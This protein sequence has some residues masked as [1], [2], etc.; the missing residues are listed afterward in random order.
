MWNEVVK[1]MEEFSKDSKPLLREEVVVPGGIT[2]KDDIYDELFKETNDDELDSLTENCLRI[3]CCS[4][5]ILLR[6][7]LEDQLPG[8]K[9]F[10]PSP[11]VMNET[12]NTPKHNIICECDFSQLDRQ[13][14]ERPQTGSIALSGMVCFINNKTPEYMESLS[15]EEKHKMIERTLL[16]KKDYIKK[17]QEMK[18]KVR[19]RKI[20]IMEERKMKIAKQAEKKEQRK[21]S[22]DSKLGEYSGFWRSP[23]EMREKLETIPN[24]KQKDAL[25]TQIKYRKFVLG[26]KIMDKGL[27]QLQSGKEKFTTEQLKENLESVLQGLAQTEPEENVNIQTVKRQNLREDELTKAIQMKT[28]KQKRKKTEDHYGFRLVRKTILHRWID[29]G[30]EK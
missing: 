23:S 2:V 9:Y 11:E 25:T 26:T 5:A 4:G 14:K 10:S 24:T 17:Y 13:L 6:H 12:R 7:Q 30:E 3:L 1:Q 15:D 27:L 18:G 29:G 22:L 8:G 19:Q 16:E 28:Q 21:E 20:D